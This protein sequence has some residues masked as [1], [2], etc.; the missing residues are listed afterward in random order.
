MVRGVLAR[1]SELGI[2][3][4]APGEFTRRAFLHGRIDLT[5]AESVAAIIAAD[6]LAEARAARR[7]LDGE[8]AEAVR[9]IGDELHDEIASLE[10]GLDFADAMHLA[11]TPADGDFITFDRALAR[12]AARLADAP[13][14]RLA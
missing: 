12:R 6:D 13:A 2:A 11:A 10:A 7:T 8:L 1:L 9:A 14:A 4:A 3:A 5:R